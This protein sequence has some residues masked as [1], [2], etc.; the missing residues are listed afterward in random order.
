MAVSTFDQKEAFSARLTRIRSGRQFE[1]EDLVGYQTQKRAAK[2]FKA[3]SKKPKR[4]FAD[5]LMVLIALLSGMS[6]VTVGRYAYFR[7]SQI[8]GLPPAF[9]D[10]GTRGMV[11]F[12]FVLAMVLVVIFHLTSRARFQA[13]LLG[14]V[15]MHYGEAAVAASAPQFWAQI[16]T[17]DY[18][19]EMAAQGKDFVVHP[20]G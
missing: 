15:V 17:A 18:A 14:C 3:R 20:A 9:Y 16:F 8:E 19:A 12:A 6:A 10:L 1:H 7:L 4:S 2:I 13:L 5:R 11:M